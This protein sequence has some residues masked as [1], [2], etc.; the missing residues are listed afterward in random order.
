MD[1]NDYGLFMAVDKFRKGRV[2]REIRGSTRSPVVYMR[3]TSNKK[4]N[5][6]KNYIELIIEM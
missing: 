6:G 2:K 5:E 4:G 3:R 1:Q